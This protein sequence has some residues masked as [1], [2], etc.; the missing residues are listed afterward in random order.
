MAV[1]WVAS[2][3]HYRHNYEV[4]LNLLL[5]QNYTVHSNGR[6]QSYMQLYL[7]AG[8]GER[9]WY[10]ESLRDWR[11]GDRIPVGPRFYAPVD[12]VPVAHPVSLTMATGSFPRVRRPGRGANHPHPSSAEVK[13]R[14]ELSLYCPFGSSWPVVG[15]TL[16]WLVC[17]SSNTACQYAR[18]CN[19]LQLRQMIKCIKNKKTRM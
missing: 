2:S 9:S 19:L 17:K 13:E 8:P 6:I 18:A 12:T 4:Q 14:V 3:D 1:S 15:W 10:S 5:S 16:L 11:S 7:Y